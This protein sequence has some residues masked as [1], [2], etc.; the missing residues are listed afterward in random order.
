[1]KLPGFTAQTSLGK[2]T[3][4]YRGQY[5]YGGLAQRQRGIPASIMPAQLEETEEEIEATEEEIEA[6]DIE[7]EAEDIETE[8]EVEPEAEEDVETENGG[9][10]A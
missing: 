7:I 10:E 3:R 1:M 8:V 6:G 2:S 9:E 4:T 5:L